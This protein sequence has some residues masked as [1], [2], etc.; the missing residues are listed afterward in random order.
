MEE[1]KSADGAVIIA[2]I[3]SAA[4]IPATRGNPHMLQLIAR[5]IAEQ[6]GLTRK[7][8]ESSLPGSQTVKLTDGRSLDLS[9]AKNSRPSVSLSPAPPV[10]Q[11]GLWIRCMSERSVEREIL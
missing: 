8:C 3:T 5:Q 10:M 4:Q 2:A 9:R 7:P 11:Y 6:A 1:A